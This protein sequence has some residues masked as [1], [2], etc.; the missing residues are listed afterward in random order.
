MPEE[1][2]CRKT[3]GESIKDTAKRLLKNPSIVPRAVAEERMEVCRNCNYFK[4]KSQV[5]ELCGCYLP[6]KTSMVSMKCPL[7]KWAEWDRNAYNE[8]ENE[9]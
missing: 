5:C 1:E 4:T 2:C 9:N 7:D 6:L 8:S 3:F